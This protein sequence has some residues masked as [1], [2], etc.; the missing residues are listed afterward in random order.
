MLLNGKKLARNLRVP[1]GFVTAMRK[2]PD[3]PFVFQWGGRT[4]R[5][6]AMKWLE[7]HPG[8]RWTDYVERHRKKLRVTRGKKMG[9]KR[10]L[11]PLRSR[12]R[13]RAGRK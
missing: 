6:A 1:R 2:H 4:T 3:D 8:F 5:A 12:P 13:S 11:A 9:R 10:G 7:E